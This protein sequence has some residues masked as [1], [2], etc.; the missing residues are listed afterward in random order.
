MKLRLLEDIDMATNHTLVKFI[1]ADTGIKF[2]PKDEIP[3]P[4]PEWS[5]AAGMDKG[6]ISEVLKEEFVPPSMAEMLKMVE[7]RENAAKT[8]AKHPCPACG[9]IQVQLV[10]CDSDNLKLKCRKCF[11][12]FERTL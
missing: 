11:H 7:R 6:L 10:N 3:E 12:K 2:V 5:P 1:D 9:T 8:A 4:F